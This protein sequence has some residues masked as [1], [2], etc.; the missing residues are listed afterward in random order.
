MKRLARLLRYMRPYLP[1]T[2]LSVVLMAVVGAMQ[3]FRV[4]LIKPIVD[5]VLSPAD[6]PARVLVFT[7]PR[8]GIHVDLQRWLPP[9]FHNAW[10][11]VAL[12]LVASAVLKAVCDYAGTL[13]A[14]RAGFGMITD[15]RN[16]LYESLLGRSSAFFQRHATGTLVSTLINDVE[17]VQTAMSTV[18]SDLLQQGFTL[19]F[20]VGAVILV[21]G[22]LG[23][24]LLLFVP[25]IVVS[26]RR[27]GRSVRT[28]TRKGQ[29][30][31]AEIQNIVHETITG[32]GIVK[33]FGMERWEL[34]RFRGAA[35]RLLK[36]NMKS[37]AVQSISSPLMD[38][39]GAV[40]IALLLYL[41]RQLIVHHGGT[42][43]NFIAF[44]AAVM[45]LYDPV[46]KMPIYY[47]S[48]QQA[49]GA[50]QEIFQFIDTQD[51]VR[52]V[53][54]AAVLRPFSHAIEF[55]DVHFSYEREGRGDEV[56][57]GIQLTVRCGEVVALVGPSGA[58]KSTLANLVPRFYDPTGGAVLVDGQNVCEVT[59][60]SLRGQIGK[61]T[62]ETVLF[63][64]TVR[65]NIAYGRPDVPMAR[66][67]AAAR[68]ARA[69]DFILRL[70]GGYD[71]AIGER[72]TRLSGGERQRLAIA[73][74]LLR[75]APILIL[76]EA[77]SALDSESEA[78]VQSALMTLME[79]RTVLVIAHRLS[80]V[81][82]ADRIVVIE[83]G[84]ITE[85]GRHEDLLANNGTY[86]RLYA[87]QFGE[88]ETERAA[89]AD[90]GVED[91]AAV[92]AGKS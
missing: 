76:D 45:M 81:R 34:T 18:L 57:K 29:D 71:A 79:N 90:P 70:P 24:V 23:W 48:F 51:E 40:A 43:G 7:V 28:T 61:V 2:L 58:G 54:R 44:L 60:A 78:A 35:A 65:N 19:I 39:L 10:T 47:N 17:R 20:M 74:A 22:K 27:I 14:N 84:T 46:R 33:A 62:Q 30:K 68:A 80:T 8:T 73:R 4:L 67:E 21:G 31:L 13:L 9:H 36:A 11:V 26:A 59:L 5:N 55:R 91:R 3:A 64:D 89:E 72:G 16:D 50:S 25:V 41:G 56:L 63:N 42:A 66:I 75:D 37:V 77:T 83:G 38:G 53:K 52:E 32:H 69:H 92:I 85:S 82:R 86:S 12:A 6:S 88:R 1:E 49:V 87:L 15:L